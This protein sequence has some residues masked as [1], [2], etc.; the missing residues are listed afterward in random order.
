MFLPADS[1]GLIQVSLL[2]TWP[3]L[4]Y[5]FGTRAAEGW[6]AT[7]ALTDL[8]QIHSPHVVCADN[9]TGRLGE[10]D[11]L[12]SATPG[13]MI[14]VRTADCLPL[15]LVDANRRAVAAVHAGW[16]GTIADIAGK[17]VE[18]MR[19]EY[20]SRPEDLYAV[21][22]PHISACCFEV[23]LEVAVEFQ[24]LF[25]E[26]TDLDRRTRVDLAEANRR[27][28]LAAGLPAGQILISQLCTVCD[29][30]QFH[31]FRRDRERA[32]RLVNVISVRE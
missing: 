28:L 25:P 18:R 9:G 27:Q 10:G 24:P 17:T 26:R 15:F 5:G 6:L 29:P 14:A 30:A 1:R 22:G 8:K 7:Q 13:R 21:T 16:R 31:S 19:Q 23:G 12:I 2:N 32:G 20:G 3:W 4:D 11:A